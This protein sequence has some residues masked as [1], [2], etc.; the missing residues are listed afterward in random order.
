MTI[1]HLMIPDAFPSSG[2]HGTAAYACDRNGARNVWAPMPQRT[3]DP[4]KAT[5]A[6]C[7]TASIP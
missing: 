3:L 7:K 6:S 4:A 1:V 5:C 2:L